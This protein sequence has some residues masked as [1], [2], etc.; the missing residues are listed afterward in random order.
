MAPQELLAFILSSPS[1][2]S[3]EDTPTSSQALLWKQ[4]DQLGEGERTEAWPQLTALVIPSS[5]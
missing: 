3:E 2:T 4:A 1:L 5:P